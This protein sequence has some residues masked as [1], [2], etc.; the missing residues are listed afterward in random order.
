M[1]SGEVTV[2]KMIGTGKIG[3]QTQSLD[4]WNP[5]ADQGCGLTGTVWEVTSD[6]DTSGAARHCLS[7]SSETIIPSM[8]LMVMKAQERNLMVCRLMRLIKCE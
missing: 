1:T 2:V 5:A 3:K 8:K 7:T 6:A 4:Q